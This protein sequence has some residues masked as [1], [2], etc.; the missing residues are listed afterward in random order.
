MVH[1]RT[2]VNANN[3]VEEQNLTI[4]IQFKYI[5]STLCTGGIKDEITK[6]L[7]VQMS[8]RVLVPS[9]KDPHIP[10]DAKINTYQ[11]M[12]LLVLQYEDEN[13]TRREKERSTLHAEELNPAQ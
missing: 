2:E 5:G 8:L 12:L 13:W 11:A 3:N 6:N 7:Q 9:H 10:L 4:V 1:S